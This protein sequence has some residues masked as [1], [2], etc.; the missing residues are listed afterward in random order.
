MNEQPLLWADHEQSTDGK[1]EPP[2]ANTVPVD[3]TAPPKKPRAQK[4]TTSAPGAGDAGKD[5]KPGLLTVSEV[6]RLA[7]ST[8][9]TI[10]IA[11]HG[12]VSGLNARYPY[13]VY[14]DLR[15][16]DATL[17]AIMQKR[18]FEA[19]N[20]RFEDGDMVVAHGPLTLFE[21]QGKYQVRVT[22][23]RPY[24]EG[25]IQ[26]RI[27]A[28]KRKLQAE[29]LF[30]DSLKKPLPPYP[31]TIGLVTSTRGAA[32]RDVCVTVARR[33]PPVQIFVRSV[34]VQGEGAVDQICDG[35]RFFEERWP[36]DLVILA[37]GGGSIQD[38]EPFSTE[39]VARMISSM[40]TPVVTGIGHEPDVS[41]ADLVADRRGSTP[42]AAAE[43]S[44]PDIHDIH[45]LLARH[46]ALATRYVR[47]A[48]SQGLR[49][50]HTVR[51]RPL[52]D[53][54][55]FLLGGHMQRLERAAQMVPGSPARG[56]V[57][58]RHRLAMQQSRRIYRSR[59]ELLSSTAQGLPQHAAEVLAAGRS[60]FEKESVRLD[61]AASRLRA[62]SPVAVLE[63][64]YSITFS[65]KTGR[66]VR[67]PAD[68]PV[69]E[70]LRT[71]LADG[72]IASEVV[73]DGGP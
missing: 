49:S 37:R 4:L 1:E 36:V 15:D 52:Y 60:A 11:V 2:S 46:R 34:T 22:S 17:P 33:F 47:D 63:R 32:I 68:V 14:F 19:L 6:N 54:S 56:L 27:E 40:N 61:R 35:L 71:R 50:V 65:G 57:R 21:K 12:E 51:G 7:K 20:F 69:G 41:I 39:P 44:V 42:T 8:L 28:L 58:N 3:D 70:R 38:L 16:A 9:E 43:A 53:G 13:F 18:V 55:E 30:D 31:S 64:G 26:Q 67:S 48:C 45:S 72:E 5:D 62:L 10:R 23:L 73:T 24:G 59:N 29:G 66:I 25:E